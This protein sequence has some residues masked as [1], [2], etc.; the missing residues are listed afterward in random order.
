VQPDFASSAQATG[1]DLWHRCFGHISS[2]H[3]KSLVEHQ[4]VSNCLLP[5]VPKSIPVCP[6]CMDGKQTQDPF[7]LTAS[8]RSVPL[9]LVHSDLHGPLPATA[10]GY[11]YWISFTDDA[12]CY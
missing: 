12:S 10:N 7:P 1:Y 9:E 6:A 5:S 3:L 4:M 8:C 2:N 11:K